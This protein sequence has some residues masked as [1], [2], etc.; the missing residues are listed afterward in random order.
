[1][2]KNNGGLSSSV[3][4]YMSHELVRQASLSQPQMY[5][6]IKGMFKDIFYGFTLKTKPE[7][8]SLTTLWSY[9]LPLLKKNVRRESNSKKVTRKRSDLLL[10][11]ECVIL[12]AMV[13][14]YCCSVLD[15][16]YT[17]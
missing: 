4:F 7:T 14:H 12:S 1:M 8:A 2:N 16:P 5:V 9:K 3:N 6:A 15:S 10:A 13:S 17:C 11:E